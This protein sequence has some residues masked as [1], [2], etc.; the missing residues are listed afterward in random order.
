[1]AM[2]DEPSLRI[3]EILACGHDLGYSYLIRISKP[4]FT[5]WKHASTAAFGGTT[6]RGDTMRRISCL[7]ISVAALALCSDSALANAY[8]DSLEHRI[9]EL[10]RRVEAAEGGYSRYWMPGQQPFFAVCGY[11][12]AVPDSAGSSFFLFV[13]TGPQPYCI[14]PAPSSACPEAL[15]AYKSDDPKEGA[16]TWTF[17]PCWRP[18]E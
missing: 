1:M 15:V 14:R 13:T 18:E 6:K 11:G 5:S 17:D 10:E 8:T 16:F 7:A 3:A 12:I 2:R 9:H 4:V